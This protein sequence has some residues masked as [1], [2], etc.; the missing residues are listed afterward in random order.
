MKRAIADREPPLAGPTSLV[1]VPLAVRREPFG[2]CLLMRGD[3]RPFALTG[4]WAGGGALI[5]SEPISVA[6]PDEDPFAVLER[7]PAVGAALEQ[8]PD[9]SAPETD[10]QPPEAVGGGWFGYLGYNLGGLIERVPPPPPRPRVMPGF[11]LAFYDHLL[12]LDRTGRWWFEALWTAGRD[13]ELRRRFELL[14]ARLLGGPSPRRRC[15]VGAF[16]AVAPGPAGHLVAVRDC[17]DRIASGEIFQANVCM[18]LEA[19]FSGDPLDL[20][21]KA[22]GALDPPF[23]A[24]VVGGRG[25]VCSLSPELF[26]RRREREVVTHPIKGT[27]ARGGVG[28]DD[29]RERLACSEK[30]RAENVMIVDLMRNDLGRVCEP[31]TIEVDEL[32]VPHPAPGVW[33][34]VSA[35]SGRLRAGMGDRALLR[36]AFPPGSVTGAPKIQAMRVI[37][38]L[39]A[40]G[41]EAYTGAVGYAS[42]LGGLELNVAIR[43]LEL[44]GDR[45]WL[46][47]G[48]GIV[49]D[50]RPETELREC[51]LKA[52]PIVAAA[53]G[54][55]VAERP[56]GS[57]RR[58]LGAGLD[59]GDRPDPDLGVFEPVLVRDRVPIA[60]DAHLDRLERSVGELYGGSLSADV[61]ERV[62]FEAL[63]WAS[64]RLRVIAVAQPG[65]QIAVEVVAG[66]LAP[67]RPQG[68]TPLRPVVLPGGLGAHKWRDRRLLDRLSGAGSATPLIVD[69]D[70]AV[71]EAGYA[72]VLA[73]EGERLITPALDGRL[74]PGTTRARLISS[75][76]RTGVEVSE[77]PVIL[78]RLLAADAIL[79]SSSIRGVH[80]ARL[81][82]R[83]AAPGRLGPRL[84]V[85]LADAGYSLS[86]PLDSGDPVETIAGTGGRS[87]STRIT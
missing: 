44:A 28:V 78:D 18:R 31:G 69:L 32:A 24:L 22:A 43:T 67:E 61:A 3:E 62:A 40:T 5:G 35:V 58:R 10:V 57:A 23:A 72:N 36:A 45:V 81:E 12:R 87:S 13:A 73:A 51:M 21:A 59:S 39:E 7:Q 50:S 17:R 34:L 25:A 53:G 27:A 6:A 70:G 20:F 63:A 9:G 82:G 60:I 26:L 42:P 68:P 54:E 83:E 77:Q 84:V 1:R 16:A 64:G 8:W 49:A 15:S 66:P 85:A 71:L 33:H 37:A 41:R 47:V 2:A 29:G 74:L 48:G 86:S 11:E 4:E 30:D 52:A 76:R 56:A 79:L 14:R 46:G 38:E 65:G 55:L 80:A 19:G 75:L